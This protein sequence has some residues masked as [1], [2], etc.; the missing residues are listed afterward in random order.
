MK[1]YEII[2]LSLVAAALLVAEQ[3]VQL[4][5]PEWRSGSDVYLVWL[6][7]LSSGRGPLV[8]GAFALAGGLVMDASSGHF[9]VFHLIYYLVPVALGA[10]LRSQLIVEYGV[11]GGLIAAALLLG[12][13]LAML[14][15]AVL[16]GMLPDAGY[17]FRLNYWPLLIVSLA[18]LFSWRW[19]VGLSQPLKAAR[20]GY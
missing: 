2:R 4:A 17:F 5:R 11:L 1:P 6:L 13:I 3:A 15:V 10:L 12:K 8:A 16:G 19:L 9:A 20:L 18:V 14:A 7:I